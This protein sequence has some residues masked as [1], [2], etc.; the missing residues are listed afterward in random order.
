MVKETI[1][2]GSGILTLLKVPKV[3]KVSKMS[4]MSYC[5]IKKIVLIFRVKGSRNGF[6]RTFENAREC[7]RGN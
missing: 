7:V 6:L 2:G 5:V 4:K 1:C 3:P